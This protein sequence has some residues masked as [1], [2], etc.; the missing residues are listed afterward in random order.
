[1]GLTIVNLK[2]VFQTGKNMVRLVKMYN[3][4]VSEYD[5]MKFPDFFKMVSNLP[6]IADP[7]GTEWI[8]R[9]KFTLSNQS[10]YRDCDDKAILIA[11]KLYRMGIP[12]RFV[13]SSKLPSKQLHHVW[14]MILLNGKQYV[15]DATY[16]GYYLG[17]DHKH[18]K[19]VSLTQWIKR[20][21]N[22]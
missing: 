5:A 18:T 19:R 4:D 20:G 21:S 11:S 2:N 7:K 8:Q 22:G 10:R 1:M 12:F 6:Y 15:I 3:S 14:V 9:P 13:A 16:P 17:Q